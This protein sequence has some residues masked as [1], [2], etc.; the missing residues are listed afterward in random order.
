MLICAKIGKA[1]RNFGQTAQ[2]PQYECLNSEQTKNLA[3]ISAS[4]KKN[5]NNYTYSLR[6][7]KSWPKFRPEAS[8]TACTH[9]CLQCYP[10]AG[11]IF[12]QSQRNVKYNTLEEVDTQGEH[13]NTYFNGC[14][15]ALPTTLVTYVKYSTQNRNVKYSQ[16]ARIRGPRGWGTC[17]ASVP[18]PTRDNLVGLFD[19]VTISVPWTLY[20]RCLCSD[21][22]F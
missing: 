7:P 12:C 5:G 6:K 2:K 20:L 21:W 13:I 16:I 8:K 19:V 10:K 17:D 22:L 14:H 3:E 18:V 4:P 1:G 15:T 11:L 9:S